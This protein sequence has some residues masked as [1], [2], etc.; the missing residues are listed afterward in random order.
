[1]NWR[2]KLFFFF[3]SRDKRDAG[4]GSDVYS[5]SSRKRQLYRVIE[6]KNARS[7]RRK[8]NEIAYRGSAKTFNF[9]ENR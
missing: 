8:V 3:K 1:M 2:V 5:S 7:F 6:K 9:R 4:K